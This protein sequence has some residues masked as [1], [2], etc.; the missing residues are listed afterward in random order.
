MTSKLM[1]II[2]TVVAAAALAIGAAALAGAGSGRQAAS[3]ATGGS[4]G[5]QVPGGVGGPPGGGGPGTGGA[6][7]GGPGFGTPVTGATAQKVEQAALA[8]VPGQVERAEQLAD[9]SYIVHVITSGGEVHVAVSRDLQSVRT[10]RGPPVGPPPAGGA[11][12]SGS[13]PSG[14]AG[15]TTS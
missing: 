7:A 14:I 15:T 5:S 4:G 10:L 8:K 3:T 6:G 11:T 1:K 13:T 2:A 9:G 12:P